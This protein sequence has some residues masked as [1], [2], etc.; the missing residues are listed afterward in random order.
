MPRDTTTPTII[1]RAKKSALTRRM[2]QT[3]FMQRKSGGSIAVA[4]LFDE[5][6]I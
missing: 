3:E 5:S 6:Q 4:T 1:N 2:D